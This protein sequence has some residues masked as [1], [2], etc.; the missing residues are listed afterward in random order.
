LQDD[1]L[2]RIQPSELTRRGI[3]APLLAILLCALLLRV[4]LGVSQAYIHDENNTAI[5]LADTIS[6]APSTL[7]LPLRGPNHG[8]LPAYV[9]KAGTLLF[10][11]SHLARRAM[12]MILS[13]VLIGLIYRLTQQWYGTTAARWAAALMAFNE[14]LL[15][16]S[17]RATAHVPYLLCVTAAVYAFSRFLATERPAYLM[18]A[19]GFVGLAFYSKEH[20]VLLLPVFLLVLLHARYRPWLKR[21]QPYLACALFLAIVV[22]DLLWNLKT[23]RTATI[24]LESQTR[25][26]TTYVDHLSRIGGVGLSPYP[27]MFYARDV[28]Q[29]VSRRITGADLPDGTSEYPSLNPVLG[30]V[31]VGGVLMTTMRASGSDDL[32]RFLLV[33]F[34]FVFGFF[35]FIKRGTPPGRLDPVSWIWVEATIIPAVILAAARLAHVTGAWRMG[36]WVLA[37]AALVFASAAPILALAGN[38]VEAAQEAVAMTR[39]VFGLIATGMVDIVRERPLRSIVVT[40]IVGIVVGILIG[41]FARRRWRN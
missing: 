38:G 25:G 17:A 15:G 8:A 4:E 31:L 36:A 29:S 22:P 32:R 12:H 16:V 35:T 10:G 39:H 14:Y 5:P 23:D 1:A 11:T 30:L 28:V 13:L 41:W 2:S 7:N 6:F 34:W 20:A 24:T 33:F 9:V 3:D 37:G 21:P 26:Q 27:V 18:T 40:L 19:G